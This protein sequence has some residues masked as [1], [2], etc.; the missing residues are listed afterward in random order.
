MS[1][2][3]ETVVPEAAPKYNTLAPGTMDVWEIPPNIEAAIL[4]R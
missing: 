4:D 3:C 2:T 1:E